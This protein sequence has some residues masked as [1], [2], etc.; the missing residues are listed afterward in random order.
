MPVVV[1]VVFIVFGLFFATVGSR[2]RDSYQGESWGM[3]AVG[4]PLRDMSR[5]TVI[6]IGCLIA[7]VGV[8]G[9]FF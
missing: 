4:I 2:Y 1:S 5:R 3:A 6:G 8:A 7:L 9:L